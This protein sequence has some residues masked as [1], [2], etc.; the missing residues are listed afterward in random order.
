[1]TRSISTARVAGRH[2]D[3]PG[4][5]VRVDPT[6]CQGYGICVELAGVQFDYDDWGFAQA[7]DR[8]ISAHELPAVTK[9]VNQC[10]IRAIR[11]SGG[12]T[13]RAQIERT[14]Q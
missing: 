12:R 8:D 6:R 7:L 13:D 14:V 3:G 9:A 2:H 5:R 1:V 10:P 11:W 4:L